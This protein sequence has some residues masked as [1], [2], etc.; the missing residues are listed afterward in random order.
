MKSILFVLA[1]MI[2]ACNVRAQSREW[3]HPYVGYSNTSVM[4]ID[5]VEFQKNATVVHAAVDA[6]GDEFGISTE[7]YLSANGKALS[8]KKSQRGEAWQVSEIRIRHET[9]F[10]LVF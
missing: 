1:F 2:A 4:T 5:R 6:N 9:A 10:L 3:S 8:Y 7:A